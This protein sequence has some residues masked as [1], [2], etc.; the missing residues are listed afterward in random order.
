MSIGLRANSQTRYPFAQFSKDFK[1]DS[2]GELYL[3]DKYERY[4]PNTGKTYINDSIYDGLSESKLLSIL[5]KPNWISKKGDPFSKEY[6]PFSRA[7]MS[8]SVHVLNYTTAPSGSWVN[9]T[10]KNGIVISTSGGII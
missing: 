10:I 4:D 1:R 7:K 8:D 2:T 5:G 3:R 9:F 6:D